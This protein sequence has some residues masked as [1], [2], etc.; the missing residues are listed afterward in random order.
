VSELFERIRNVLF[1]CHEREEL[2]GVHY[3][4]ENFEVGF[5]REIDGDNFRLERIDRYGK[6]W[7]SFVGNLDKVMRVQYG[8]QYMKAVQLLMERE[9]LSN[10]GSRGAPDSL[11][12][13]KILEFVKSK[14]LIVG[15]YIEDGSTFHGYVRAYSDDH[16]ELEEI[17]FLGYEDGVRVFPIEDIIRLC[18]GSPD[19]ESRQFLN[20][21]RLGL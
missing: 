14:N 13:L 10:G 1:Q 9:K 16:V 2:A 8:T 12:T 17:S 4:P 11:D 6:S 21:V 18:Y 7:G 20:R 3:E 19:E 15:V 5:V